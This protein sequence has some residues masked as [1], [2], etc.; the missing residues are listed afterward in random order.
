MPKHAGGAPRKITRKMQEQI[1]VLLEH[2]LSEVKICELLKISRVTL[3]NA[4]KERQ[5]LNMVVDAKD[6]ADRE[7]VKSLYQRAIGYE[8]PEVKVFCSE[9]RIVT[10]EIVKQYPPD[11]GAITLWL[12]NRNRAKQP[13]EREFRRDPQLPVDTQRP[14][15]FKIL[16]RVS[17]KEVARIEA[18]QG[19][20]VAALLGEDFVSEVTKSEQ[21][22]G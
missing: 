19:S 16:E 4:K 15:M 14:A 1:C 20:R 9:G 22:P 5:F 7:V 10:H 6:A 18:A 2:G 11:V 3:W 21:Q 17:G 13:F 12:Q 8:H